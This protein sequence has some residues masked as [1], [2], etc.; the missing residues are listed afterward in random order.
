[1]RSGYDEYKETF[2][3]MPDTTLESLQQ[4]KTF[5]DTLKDLV[6]DQEY[7]NVK[8]A[9]RAHLDKIDGV[10]M[11]L[12]IDPGKTKYPTG[13]AV[14]RDATHAKPLSERLQP[15]DP[16]RQ[17][18]NMLLRA[19]GS[20]R[21]IDYVLAKKTQP[22]GPDIYSE[23]SIHLQTA[24]QKLLDESFKVIDSYKDAQRPLPKE[25][26]DHIQD[27]QK[28]LHKEFNTAVVQVLNTTGLDVGLTEAK[29]YDELINYYR[30][31]ASVVDVAE[32]MQTIIK[33][34]QVDKEGKEVS[35]LHI[36]TSHPITVKTQRQKDQLAVMK[37]VGG[38]EEK[39]FHTA[40]N[41]AMQ[42]ANQAFHDLIAADDRKLGAQMRKKNAA[43]LKN[44]YAVTYTIQPENEPS[45]A[46]H[47]YS[48]RCGS[49]TYVG[50]GREKFSESTGDQYTGENLL[51]LEAAAKK[52]FPNHQ[53][54]HIG[55]LLTQHSMV[56]LE[57]QN[58]IIQATKAESARQGMEW[59]HTATNV[60]GAAT[61]KSRIAESVKEKIAGYEKEHGVKESVSGRDG[62]ILEA[63]FT[64]LVASESGMTHIT[65]CASGQDR[66]GT[67]E[68][69]KAEM[70]G[71]NTY[72][73][74]GI[75]VSRTN[76]AEI[77]SV[78]GHVATLASH[79]VP[80]SPGMKHDSE[81]KNLF[82]AI[83]AAHLYP[84][85]LA[86]T[87]KPGKVVAESAVTPAMATLNECYKLMAEAKPNEQMIHRKLVEWSKLLL[88]ATQTETVS[89]KTDKTTFTNAG[90]ESGKLPTIV[91]QQ[92]L[93][94]YGHQAQKAANAILQSISRSKDMDEVIKQILP[95]I[96]NSNDA[97]AKTLKG[98]SSE[99][100]PKVAMA[101]ET[102]SL[103]N[104]VYQLLD[105]AQQKLPVNRPP[106]SRA[107]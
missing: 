77:R 27:Q 105:V 88:P 64:A 86:N 60:L 23:E 67:I 13:V 5:R 24:Y 3:L 93:F 57:H 79:S 34:K 8:F 72:K 47:L 76:L 28:K 85:K 29:E 52:H 54:M 36:E 26:L 97:F 68:E 107:R 81:P 102:S 106:S 50:K 104:R 61:N 30:D 38:S 33:D 42:M 43:T 59:S 9:I 11:S 46:K 45:L 56:N 32:S 31:L 12:Q 95:V 83:I 6:A 44:G 91:R 98:M 94:G 62:R 80:G 39:N 71:V 92:T 51:Q 17:V 96:Q 14:I 16:E 99:Q 53:K 18:N 25:T 10:E 101:K 100:A 22:G 19:L 74:F 49:M 65:T 69:L 35:L 2:E 20:L 84:E 7:A 70:F 90:E 103:L 89:D 4:G 15:Y 66:T 55:M 87:N 37:N 63:A 58:E 78:G 73:A 21:G 75:D 40:Q 48:L 82:P 41:T 1:M